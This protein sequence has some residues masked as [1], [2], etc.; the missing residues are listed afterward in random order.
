MRTLN[1]FTLDFDI[2]VQLLF[3]ISSL[4]FQMYSYAK[5]GAASLFVVSRTNIDV[6]GNKY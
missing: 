1:H 5:F 6:Q 4:M 2:Q 3:L